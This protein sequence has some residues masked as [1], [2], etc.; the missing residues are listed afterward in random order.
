MDPRPITLSDTDTTCALRTDDPDG[1][2][3]RGVAQRRD[4]AGSSRQAIAK[5]NTAADHA[6]AAVPR[7]TIASR[8]RGVIAP[9]RKR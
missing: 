7:V 2:L 6:A 4:D 3:D 9:G 8:T 1:A 5:A